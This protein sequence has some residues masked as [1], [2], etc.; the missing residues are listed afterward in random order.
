MPFRSRSRPRAAPLTP[1]LRGTLHAGACRE[2]LMDLARPSQRN[3]PGGDVCIHGCVYLAL[4]FI[5]AFPPPIRGRDRDPE[6]EAISTREH[7][8]ARKMIVSLC[9]GVA[10]GAG[11]CHD[12][13]RSEAGAPRRAREHAGGAWE[14]AEQMIGRFEIDARSGSS[15]RQR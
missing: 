15:G 10:T 14:S 1:R 2:R 11:L 4:P 8:Y 5:A 12:G 13:D 6:D 3:G 7:I 9:V